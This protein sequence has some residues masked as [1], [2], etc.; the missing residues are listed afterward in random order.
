MFKV[1]DKVEGYDFFANAFNSLI[2]LYD[3]ELVGY[4]DYSNMY[5]NLEINNIFVFEG[6]R[7]LGYGKKLLSYLFELKY[8][9]I[10]LE[11]RISNL[12]AIN[13]YKSFGFEIVAVRK[14]YYGNED[15]YLMEVKNENTCD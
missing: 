6:F 9:N 10:T 14:K 11:V 15:A 13:L 5:D 3:D 4:I 2:G 8:N 12:V 1:I 7:S